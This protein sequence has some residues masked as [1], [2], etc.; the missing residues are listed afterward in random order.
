MTSTRRVPPFAICSGSTTSPLLRSVEDDP[1][2]ER[3]VERREMAARGQG[4]FAVRWGHA[5]AAG[6]GDISPI[7]LSVLAAGASR[8]PTTARGFFGSSSTPVLGCAA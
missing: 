6:G 4:G 2:A 5:P 7:L 8:A 1:P 3:G